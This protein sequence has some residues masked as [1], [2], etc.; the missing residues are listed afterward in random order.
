MAEAIASAAHRPT[1]VVARYGGEE[2]VVLLPDTGGA[3]AAEVEDGR[4]AM[5]KLFVD[6][7][8]ITAG[9]FDLCWPVPD[10]ALEPA[11][12]IPVIAEGP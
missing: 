3:G 5:Y 7:K 10:L 8:I 6:S 9:D 1:D 11:G 4:R 2:F 12:A